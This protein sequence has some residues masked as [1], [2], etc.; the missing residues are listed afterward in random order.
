MIKSICSETS[1]ASKIY[2]ATDINE[3]GEVNKATNL[4]VVTV[5]TEP[6]NITEDIKST[7]NP[8]NWP[9]RK[10]C[11]ILF[12]LTITGMLVLTTST[13]LLPA[14]KELREEFDTSE[15]AV[16]S[17]VSVNSFFTGISS[18]A[19]A[20]YSD[21]F[22][23]RRKVFLLSM[24][25]FIISTILCTLA[26]RIW[27]LLILCAIQACGSS[28]SVSISAG[29]ISDIYSPKDRGFAFGIFSLA[30][31]T[32]T[33]TAAGG[34]I[35]QYLNWRWLFYYLA[36]RFNPFA[37]LKLLGYPNFVL[38]A[39]Y[40]SIVVSMITLQ[41]I[42]VSRNLSTRS[43]HLLPSSIGLLF[44]APTLGC[45]L[46]S[47]IGGKYSDF[48]L[49]KARKNGVEIICPEVRIKSATPGALMVPCSYLIFG[50]LLIINFNIY[51]LMILW[52]FA[53]FGSYIIYS[54]LSPYLID[55]CPG[56][57]ASAIALSY[58]MR[59]IT[60][61]VIS[62]FGSL[63]EDFLGTGWYYTLI[64]VMCFLPTFFL[65]LVYF[66]GNRWKENFFKRNSYALH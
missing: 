6:I 31:A 60:A 64:F 18:I 56:L 12:V 58:C 13:V 32:L 34:F 59:L 54:S 11:L 26:N 23:R 9:S 43:Y 24:I 41:N 36:T 49:Q 30:P 53:V 40:M 22:S 3:I 38:T 57:S 29:I 63:M 50:W 66:N 1:E 10:K 21:R 39:I 4:N 14:L 27:Q 20:A 46:G 37:T 16:N 5:A 52:F 7:N 17:L 62:I 51:V 8:K 55:V 15:V 44:I 25:L 61:G 45:S 65:V 19:W 2:E 42:S 28:S 48:V 47:A 33:G 35:I